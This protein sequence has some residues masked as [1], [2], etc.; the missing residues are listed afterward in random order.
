MQPVQDPR[1]I[2][3]NANLPLAKSIARRM[4]MHL[5]MSVALVEARVE[6]FND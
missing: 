2:A 6:R 4:S 5:G 3:G 1:L